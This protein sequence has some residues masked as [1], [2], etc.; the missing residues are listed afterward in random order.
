M[1]AI[2]YILKGYGLRAIQTRQYKSN[3]GEPLATGGAEYAPITIPEVEN[4]SI[5]SEEKPQ[6]SQLGT[7]VFSDLLLRDEELGVSLYLDTVLFD[8]SMSKIIVKTTIPGR[9][10]SIKEYVADDDYDITI[11]GA[12]VS[13][14]RGQYPLDKIR[15]LR[16]LLKLSRSLEVVSTL[17]QLWEIDQ[18]VVQDYHLPQREGYENIQLFEIKAISDIPIQFLNN[19]KTINQ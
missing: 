8:V 16:D 4:L 14:T 13:P 12:I 1:S 6:V 3:M 10:G 11:K 7:P 18:L 9:N 2:E 17:L 19:D 5:K 15:D